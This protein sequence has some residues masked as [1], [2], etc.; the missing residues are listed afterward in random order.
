MEGVGFALDRKTCDSVIAFQPVSSR[1][2]VLTLEGTI[3][4]HIVAVYAPTEIPADSSKNQFY[5][6]LQQV[7]DSLPHSEFIIVAGDT[8]AHSSNWQ[9]L[10][11][12]PTETQADVALPERSRF[13]SSGLLPHTK[14][15]PF[16]LPGQL[17]VMR[18]ADCGSDHHLVV[19]K[20]KLRLNRNKRIS[21]PV[22]RRDWSR[23][24]DPI[25][26]QQFELKLRNRFEI[27]KEPE[28]ADEAEQF[29]SVTVDCAN[30]FC[31]IMRRRTQAWISNE[32]LD[33]MDQRKKCKCTDINR[34]RELH[35][36]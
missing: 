13:S 25:C 16:K 28:N 17:R 29:A 36:A 23:L 8:N 2:A 3:R 14:P 4:T 32:C 22:S 15:I 24:A 35:H 12:T 11:S 20:M 18:G 6:Q 33:M 21:T 30:A 1:I 27:L 7:I 31:P 19:M 9:Q 34:Y 26:K 5:S 10:L